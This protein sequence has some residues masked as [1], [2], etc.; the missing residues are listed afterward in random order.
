VFDQGEASPTSLKLFNI[1][2]V[3]ESRR[4]FNKRTQTRKTK[5]TE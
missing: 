4:V 3:E 5:G 2:T 1:V